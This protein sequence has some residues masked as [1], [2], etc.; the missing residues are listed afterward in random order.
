MHE[1]AYAAH[2]LA[3]SLQPV[4]P[5]LLEVPDPEAT[6]LPGGQQATAQETQAHH[7]AE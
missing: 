4:Q 7:A 3:L 5:D 2:H 6:G 1:L